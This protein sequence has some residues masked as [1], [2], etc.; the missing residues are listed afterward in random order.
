MRSA[1]KEH[2]V[3]DIREARELDICRLEGALH[4]PMAAIPA[5]T[6]DLPTKEPLVVI[7]HH[8]ARSQMVGDFLRD[9]GFDNAVN[10]DGGIDA[11]AC[12]VDQ[13]MRR[14]R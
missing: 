6:D 5:C 11:W 2:M 12:E 4:I 14:Y 1:G 8:G 9:A 10:L 13:S 7:C 3:L